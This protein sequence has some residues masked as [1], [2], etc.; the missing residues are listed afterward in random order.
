MWKY[1]IQNVV[2]V[3]HVYIYICKSCGKSVVIIINIAI[4]Y[5]VS[6]EP[7]TACINIFVTILIGNIWWPD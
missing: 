5:E 1:L 6:K 7:E 3:N 2:F 4:F